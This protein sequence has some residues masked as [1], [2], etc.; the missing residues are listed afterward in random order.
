MIFLDLKK[1]FDTI[2]HSILLCKLKAYSVGSNSS[3]W[4]KSSLDNRTQKCFVNGSLSDSQPLTCDI[5]QGT[6]LGPLL[7]ILYINDLPNCLVNSH[8]RMYADD[9]HLTFASNDVVYPEEN[10][11]DDLTKI[12]EWLTLNNLTLHKSKTEFMLIGSRQRLNTFNRL[13]SFTIDS[14][15]IKQVEFTKSLGVYIDQNLE[16]TYR[17]YFQKNCFLHWHLE[18]KL[19]YQSAA[20][21][22]ASWF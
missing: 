9:T 16:C 11:N 14:N 5:P 1:A 3:N 22:N 4:F 18:E 2:N 19:T 7:F 15:S 21:T 6:I 8:P 13:P 12:T 17:T 20:S 10:M